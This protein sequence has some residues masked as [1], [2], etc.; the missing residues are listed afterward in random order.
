MVI[1]CPVGCAQS[2]DEAFAYK[3]DSRRDCDW[4]GGDGVFAGAGIWSSTDSDY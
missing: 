3:S 2:F 1:Y 4:S